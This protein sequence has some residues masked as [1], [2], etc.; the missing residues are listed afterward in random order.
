[1][2]VVLAYVTDC[3]PAMDEMMDAVVCRC[4]GTME[5]EQEAG[6]RRQGDRQVA[7]AFALALALGTGP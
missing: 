6:G 7:L 1:M 2:A 4:G 5:S 3:R